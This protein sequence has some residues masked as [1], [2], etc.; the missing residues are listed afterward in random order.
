[1]TIIDTH[2]HLHRQE[3]DGD[4]QLVLERA[5]QAGVAAL[6]DPAT[7]PVSCRKVTELAASHPGVYAAVGIHPH[8]AAACTPESLAEIAALSGRPK[9]VAIGEIGLDYYREIVPREIQQ[10]TLAIFLKLATLKKLPVILH[11]RGAGATTASAGKG[12]EVYRDLFRLLKENMTVPVR[13]LLHCFSGN[14][15]A[16]MEGIGMGLCL[17]FA[18]NLTFT[19]AQPLR[20]V[21]KRV[22]L[23]NLLLE[24]D[25]PYLA[26]QSLRGKRNEPA[27]L[28]ELIRTWADLRQ[29]TPE[30]VAL[31][32]ARNARRLFS[33]PEGVGL[34]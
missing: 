27:Y 32:T 29:M 10:K 4:R 11:C 2:C 26:P 17:S 33:I 31:L 21:A 14:L 24:T 7:D 16:A 34:S 9:V 28:P 19:K 20:E 12:A 23:E 25:A 5:K 22:P 1:M 30:E 15:E 8:E 18:G 3:F 6:V 13:G